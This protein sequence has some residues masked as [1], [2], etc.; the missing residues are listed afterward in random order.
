MPHG[1]DLCMFCLRDDGGFRSEEHVLPESIGN[2]ETTL[3][4]GFICDLCNNG[5]LSACDQALVQCPPL[6][7]LKTV[8][9]IRSKKKK[10]PRAEFGKAGVFALDDEANIYVR[11]PDSNAVTNGDGYFELEL[12]QR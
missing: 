12:L 11:I 1:L 4:A 10:L 8:Q 9:S 7:L 5:P 3:P 6:A 2:H